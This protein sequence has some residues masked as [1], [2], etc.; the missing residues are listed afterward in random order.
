MLAVAGLAG[1]MYKRENAAITLVIVAIAIGLV[2]VDPYRSRAINSPATCVQDSG[3]VSNGASDWIIAMAGMLFAVMLVGL[4][5]AGIYNVLH[6]TP[7]VGKRQAS[8]WYEQP[9]KRSWWEDKTQPPR[10]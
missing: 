9:R 5:G 7:T 10:R 4:I 3:C 6:R 1:Y 8:T 2:A